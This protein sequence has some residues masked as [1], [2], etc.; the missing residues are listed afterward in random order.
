MPHIVP[1][2]APHVRFADA[3][4]EVTEDGRRRRRRRSTHDSGSRDAGGEQEELV[5]ADILEKEQLAMRKKSHECPVPK[6][7]GVVRE[8]LGF[9]K[10]KT[11]EEFSRPRVETTIIPRSSGKDS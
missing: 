2:P 10:D 7:R 11:T 1:C 3:E 8:I 4:L 6:P 9:K 5:I